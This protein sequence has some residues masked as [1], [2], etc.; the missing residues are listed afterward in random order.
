MRLKLRLPF[1]EELLWDLYNFMEGIEN[2]VPDFLSQPLTMRKAACP[3]VFGFRRAY[4][5]KRK[6]KDFAK[7]ISYLKRKNLI[8]IEGPKEKK[9]IVLTSKG[10]EKVLRIRRKI[11]LSLP[12]K[13]RKD[14]KWIMIAFDILEQKR[15]IRD[16]FREKLLE[17]GFQMLQKS[18]W[19]C[20][21]DILDE[22][23][24]IIRNLGIERNVKIFLIEE[25]EV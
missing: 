17:L 22:L 20:P 25:A 21:Y 1:T 18:I 24:E 4:E 5:K 3:D 19:V 23:R 8:K 11:F 13:K 14:G 16:Y 6:R 7:L 2:M 9:A 12:K 10:K 15:K